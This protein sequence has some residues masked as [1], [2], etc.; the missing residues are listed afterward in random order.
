[1]LKCLAKK[2]IYRFHARTAYQ[3]IPVLGKKSVVSFDVFDTLLKRDVADPE[4]VFTLLERKLKTDG[5]SYAEGFASLRK[6]AGKKAKEAQP[7]REISLQDIYNFLPFENAVRCELMDMECQLELELSTPNLP[8]QQLYKTCLRQG[9]KILFLS[10]M[11]LPSDAVRKLLEKNGYTEGKLYISSES[12]FTKRL[13][14]LFSYVREKEKIDIK[15]WCHIGDH[16]LSDYFIPKNLGICSYLIDRDPRY[17]PYVDKK[18]YRVNANYRQLNHFINIR[19][20]RYTD[21]YERI[22]YTVLGPLLYGFSKWIGREIPEN[23]TIVFLAREGEL[24][25]KAFRIV[26]KRPS[27]YLHISRRAALGA[28]LSQAEDYRSVSQ[29]KLRTMKKGHTCKELASSYGLSDDE[30][31]T[32]FQSAA[33]NGEQ[34]IISEKMEEVVLDAIWPTAKKKSLEQF[35]L[36]HRYIEQLG[37]SAKCA[38]V[39]VGWRG[40]IQT[41]LNHMAFKIG[42]DTLRFTGYYIGTDENVNGSTYYNDDRMGFLFGE[43]PNL[44]QKKIREWI[45]STSSFFELMFLAVEGSTERYGVDEQGQIYPV[46]GTPDNVDVSALNKIQAL[47]NAGLQFVSDMN[48]S[49]IRESLLIGADISSCGYLALLN[50]ISLAELRSFRDFRE[51][52]GD[53]AAGVSLVS[54]HGLFYYLLH[55]QLFKADFTRNTCKALFLKSVFKLPLPYVSVLAFMRKHFQTY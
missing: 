43:N 26:S 36:L 55:P 31:K 37:L 42:G 27:V 2:I 32:V 11:Y 47:Q 48:S 24:L 53:Y 21:P 40:T 30:I 1:M 17:N 10:D 46:K 18:T 51:K 15:Q 44:S 52:D 9:K 39:D 23:E 7:D 5:K 19:L 45:K 49:P 25:Q 20:S 13:G 54:E 16:I 38:A 28:Y 3:I 34:L 29:G 8:I 12:G 22:G 6:A 14:T 35:D 33:L 4:D 50:N 41:L